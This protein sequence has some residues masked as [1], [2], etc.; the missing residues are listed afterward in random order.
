[1]VGGFDRPLLLSLNLRIGPATPSWER[2]FFNNAE[3]LEV[4]LNLPAQ[5]EI[6]FKPVWE[7]IL[8]A[9]ERSE[10]QPNLRD[11]LERFFSLWTSAFEEVASNT[12][13][14]R[15]IYKP[16]RN[17]MRPFLPKSVKIS[18]ESRMTRSAQQENSSLV[19]LTYTEVSKATL[20]GVAPMERPSQLERALREVVVRAQTLADDETTLYEFVETEESQISRHL[21]H[22]AT[23][24]SQMHG[25]ARAMAEEDESMSP[26]LAA[27]MDFTKNSSN[28]K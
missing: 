23:F 17:R 13:S 3:F 10:G 8:R 20:P 27:S 22:L 18:T 28:S 15:E 26:L 9:C 16:V 7:N 1:M 25:I 6:E 14:V 12:E 24:M 19:P 4:F 5:G 21:T 2:V 11:H